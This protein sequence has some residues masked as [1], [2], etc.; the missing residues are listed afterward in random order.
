MER[1]QGLVEHIVYHNE[2]NGYTVFSIMR[3]GEETVCVGT[4][5]TLDEGEYLVLEGEFTQHPVYGRQFKAER[6]AV[7][8]PE[9][10]YSIERYLGSGAIKGVGSALAARIVK[11]FG[12][13]TFRI[14]EDEP[15]R[16]SEIKGISE[17]KAREIYL[18]FHEKQDMRQAM[19][20]L[21]GYGISPAL[22]LRIYKA[23]GADLYTIIREN[24]Y[25]LAEDM[26]GIGFK[27]A[28]EIAQHAGISQYSEFR[29]RSGVLYVL[30]QAGA[31]GHIYLPEPELVGETAMLLDVDEEA[32]S[33]QLQ[34]LVI[35]R[36]IMIRPV[37]DVRAVYLVPAYYTE[38]ETATMLC[39]L[40]TALPMD[41]VQARRM[42]DRIEQDEQLKL[43]E[44]QTEAVLK[45]AEH[46][47]FVMTG[48]PGTGKTT[49]INAMI[50]FFE[51][52]GMDILLAAPTGRAAKRMSEATGREACTIHRLLE[53]N[54]RPDD[55]GHLQ[56]RFER[57][58]E[59]PLETDVV[60]ID[61][62]SMVDIYLM[63]ALLKAIPEGTRLIMAGDVNQLPSVGPG[64]VLRDILKTELFA[65][66]RLTRIFRQALESD[67]VRNA[68][69]INEGQQIRL[70]NKSRDFFCL[71]RY[72]AADILGVMILLIR[73]KLPDYVSAS[74]LDI[75][76]LT[77]MR[78][79]ELGVERLNKVLQQYLNP[80]SQDKKEKEFHSGILRTGDKV[81]QI[82]NNYQL[83]WEVPGQFNLVQEKGVGVFNGD[84]GVIR[85]I[86]HFAEQ[87]VVEFDEKR[88]VIYSFSQLDELELAYAVTI[89]KSQGSE[90]PA[91]ILPLLGGPRM[92]L[93]RN[94]LYTAVTRARKCV[95][96]VGDERTVARMIGNESQQ[97]RYTSLDRRMLE[98]A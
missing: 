3:Q 64:N 36:R 27:L 70:D 48:G 14:M 81:M 42:L 37:E 44:R 26:S 6:M 22:S 58:E 95:A 10:I 62:M 17:R 73:D 50:R 71:K 32:V 93:N 41:E 24:P 52:Q 85:E 92:L 40:N 59:N 65:S 75:Q 89:H 53:L 80:P 97:C 31:S 46:G 94:L 29:I 16:L 23:Y 2:E 11:R 45:S 67:I 33:G 66:V 13:E 91:V 84:L 49:T 8:V 35:E 56:A 30:Q 9:D 77:P 5:S 60:I 96:I 87:L 38:L 79:G 86:N 19:M 54:G 69:M 82:K 61:E 20:F 55:E 74:P 68:H 76:V 90:Y 21:A 39:R 1:I 34:D 72:T 18:Q 78:K 12:E 98:L 43:D 28:D 47:V 7:E 57:N 4:V 83:E 15:E 63:H 51:Y 88:Q 25:R